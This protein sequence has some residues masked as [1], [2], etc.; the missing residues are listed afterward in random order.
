LRIVYS[1][2]EGGFCAVDLRGASF[3]I[4]DQLLDCE[5]DSWETVLY[6]S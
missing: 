2:V 5:F 4:I 3:K 6:I 1:R